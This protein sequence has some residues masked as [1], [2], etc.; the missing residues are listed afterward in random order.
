MKRQHKS[1]H[2]LSLTN[3][4]DSVEHSG[5]QNLQIGGLYLNVKNGKITTQ[6]DPIKRL[7]ALV[8]KRPKN[9]NR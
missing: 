5:S 6:T 9:S 2:Q 4:P 8:H 7:Q 3:L 1:I